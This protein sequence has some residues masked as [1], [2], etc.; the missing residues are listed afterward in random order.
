ME[1][2]FFFSDRL[3][4][5]RGPFT[6]QELAALARAG[7]IPADAMV[8]SQG[9]EPAPAHRHPA[10]AAIFAPSASVGASAGPLIASFPA[11]GL[12]WRLIVLVFGIALVIPAP[13]AGLWFYRWL[14]AQV[15]LPT[16]Q[17]LSLASTVG[18]CWY[19]FA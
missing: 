13:W 16:G 8:W 17:R 14:A 7:E 18:A 19:I 15:S 1:G 11:C 12:F 6:S 10:L 5:R 2:P 3:G 9:G 4:D